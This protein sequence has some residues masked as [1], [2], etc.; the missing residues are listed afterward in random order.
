MRQ[1]Q[2]KS[3]CSDCVGYFQS[4]LHNLHGLTVDVYSLLEPWPHD[5]MRLGTN[6]FG[7]QKAWSSFKLLSITAYDPKQQWGFCQRSQC[8]R[9]L[10]VRYFIIE[11]RISTKK[12]K[13]T[14]LDPCGSISNNDHYGS[15]IF[16]NLVDYT[17][18]E[19]IHN[20]SFGLFFAQKWKIFHNKDKAVLVLYGL[21][22]LWEYSNEYSARAIFGVV[23]WSHICMGRW[24][25]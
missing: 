20:D 10:H 12:M 14:N 4:L 19:K 13:S 23:V 1:F 22:W 5:I 9:D 3:R 18:L 24:S 6:I 17:F 7:F 8:Q 2:W 21:Y 11:E 16:G 15:Y 25:T